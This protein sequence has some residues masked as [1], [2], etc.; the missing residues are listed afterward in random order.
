MKDAVKQAIRRYGY[1]LRP[2]TPVSSDSSLLIT[3]LR[4]HEINLVFDIGANNGVYAGHLRSIGYKGRIVSFEPLKSAYEALTAAARK[5]CSWEVAMRSAIG[6]TDSEVEIHI[7]AN[8]QSSSILD[9]LDAHLSAAPESIYIGLEK[10]PLRK[11]DTLAPQ[12][13]TDDSVLCIK[14]DTQGYEEYVLSGAVDTLSRAIVLQLELS[15]VQLYAGQKLMP[16]I[17][18]ILKKMG[19]NLWGMIPVFAD[20]DSGR[21]LQVDGIFCR[22]D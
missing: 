2:F 7:A 11:L 1:D 9:M 13:L 6:A 21:M 12:F 17:V 10:V 8:S 18:S 16:D 22:A 4:H 3:I 19:F 20:P 14:V 5:D 15:L